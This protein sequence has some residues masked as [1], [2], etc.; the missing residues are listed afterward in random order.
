MR[1]AQ[2]FNPDMLEQAYNEVSSQEIW[3]KES[4]EDED[5]EASLV[6]SPKPKSA[7]NKEGEL[8]RVTT[9]DGHEGGE[10]GVTF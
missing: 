8:E 9:A 4:P 5:P 3:R 7:E 2:L 1:T 10:K 6:K